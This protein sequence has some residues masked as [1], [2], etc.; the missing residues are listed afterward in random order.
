MVDLQ[1]RSSSYHEKQSH[2]HSQ[3]HHPEHVRD[4]PQFEL[5]IPIIIHEPC[6]QNHESKVLFSNGPIDVVPRFCQVLVA[7]VVPWHHGVRAK[8]HGQQFPQILLHRQNCSFVVILVSHGGIGP[9]QPLHK[10]RFGQKTAAGH[11]I[12]QPFIAHAGWLLLVQ[13][14]HGDQMPADCPI[15]VQQEKER[16]NRY[17]ISQRSQNVDQEEPIIVHEDCQKSKGAVHQGERHQRA[18]HDVVFEQLELYQNAMVHA[19]VE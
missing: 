18:V 7:I 19:S 16:A 2:Q 12:A 14:R 3:Q 13:L 10:L 11:V 17:K 4:S 1:E 15:H 9:V 5:E 8:S 6:E